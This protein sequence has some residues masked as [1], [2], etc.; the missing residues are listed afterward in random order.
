MSLVPFG[1]NLKNMIDCEYSA[2]LKFDQITNWKFGM[3]Y[4]FFVCLVQSQMFISVSVYYAAYY[5]NFTVV[6]CLYNIT[7]IC[8]QID[9][10]IF[11]VVIYVR[12]FVFSDG[13]ILETLLS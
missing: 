2:W 1:D 11:W 3:L 4:S 7:T 6:K 5:V 8:G 12:L 9:K 10:V 13:P